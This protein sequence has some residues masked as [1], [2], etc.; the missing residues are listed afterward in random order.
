MSDPAG[1]T[2]D[3][4]VLRISVPSAGDLRHIAAEIA[5][6]VAVYLGS[7]PP[8]FDRESAGAMLES[9]A[10]RVAPQNGAGDIA[11]EFHRWDS[12]L[13]ILARCSGRTSEVRYPLPD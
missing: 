12:A 11:F 1:K 7:A 10:A 4:L 3:S 13:I 8:R 9:L 5:N 2:G 6:K